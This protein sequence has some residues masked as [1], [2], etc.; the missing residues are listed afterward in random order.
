MCET[1]NPKPETAGQFQ[2]GSRRGS[3]SR[4][5]LGLEEKLMEPK[6]CQ[7]R[8]LFTSHLFF[9]YSQMFV[10]LFLFEGLKLDAFMLCIHMGG[11]AFDMF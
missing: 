7:E 10:F 8:D 3:H 6:C 11:N 5:P 1:R 4:S 2:V 9:S